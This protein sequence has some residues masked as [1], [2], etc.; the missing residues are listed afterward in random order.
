M[1]GYREHPLAE[2]MAAAIQNGTDITDCRFSGDA[3]VQDLYG[4]AIERCV[5]QSCHLTGCDFT[6]TTLSDVR[7][8]DCDFSGCRFD[9]AGLQRVSFR[10]CRAL[11]AR[12]DNAALEQV[13]IHGGCFDYANLSRTE[14]KQCVLTGSFREAS[15]GG[16]V[17]KKSTVGGCDFTGS[18]W[19]RAQ[20]GGLDFSTSEIGGT[21]FS[22]DGL[23]NVTVSAEQA[24]QLAKLLGLNIRG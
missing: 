17:W 12:F 20:I 22:L 10:D 2:T 3:G 18:D 15:F 4:L 24:V 9:D 8:E 6:H 5:F 11:G 21:L 19:I 16:S 13:R 1:T 14:L 23:K 7:F